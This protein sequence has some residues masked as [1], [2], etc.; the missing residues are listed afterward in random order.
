MAPTI[1]QRNTNTIYTNLRPI[2]QSQEIAH[3]N[4]YSS[5]WANIQTINKKKRTKQTKNKLQNKQENPQMS[6]RRFGSSPH[7]NRKRYGG[8]TR[9]R[10]GQS[11]R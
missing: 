5:K 8:L 6:S 9:L 4:V 2:K 7:T 3:M 10:W 11:K 1:Q